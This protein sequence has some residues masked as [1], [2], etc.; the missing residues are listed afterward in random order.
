MEKKLNLLNDYLFMKYMGEKGDEEQLTSF[1]NA[2]LQKTG[3]GNISSVTIV[4]NRAFSAEI[5]GGKS[6]VLDLRAVLDSGAKVNIEVQLRNRNNMDRRSLFYWS[7]E[8]VRGIKSGQNYVDVPNVIAINIID[9]EFMPE[10]DGI[11]TCFHLWEDSCKDKMLTDALEIHF[12]S[13]FKFR[14]LKE[15][16]IENNPLHRWMAFFSKETDEAT[17]KKIIQMDKAIK[18]AY[19]KISHVSFDEEELRIYEMREL[20]Q[21]DYDINMTAARREGMEKGM[22][23]GRQEGLEKGMRKGMQKGIRRGMQK[24]RQEAL[25]EMLK[26]FKEGKSVEEIS[27]LLNLPDENESIHI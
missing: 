15:K 3:K 8:F 10:I 17:I 16:D 2:V 5:A 11:Q 20:A 1:L 22:R 26:L 9:C 25:S 21:M 14:Q 13:M 23:K 24:G 6:C 7:R 19:G 27:R 12:V 4:K 18:K